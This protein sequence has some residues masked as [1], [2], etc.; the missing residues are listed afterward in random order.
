MS[1]DTQANSA[2]LT[3]SVLPGAGVRSSATPPVSPTEVGIFH[4]YAVKNGEYLG[5]IWMERR[6]P[7]R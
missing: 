6:F 2:A 1:Q 3:G 5:T 7:H 4:E